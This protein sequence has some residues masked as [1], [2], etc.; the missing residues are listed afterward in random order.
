MVV[1]FREVKREDIPQQSNRRRR[2][3]RK[4]EERKDG[5]ETKPKIEKEKHTWRG[6]IE[7]H[8]RISV[9]ISV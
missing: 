4:R 2:E 9:L 5:K 7:I 3:M 8:C 6:A 1:G